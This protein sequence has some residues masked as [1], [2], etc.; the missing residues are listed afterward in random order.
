MSLIPGTLPSG[1]CYGTPQ[2]LL[3]L[4]AQYLDVPAFAVS[5]KVLYSGTSPMP[6]TDF[7]WVD[8][9]GGTT[10]ILKLYNEIIGDYEEYPFQGQLS[11]AGAETLISGKSAITTLAPNDLFLVSQAGTSAVLKK[12][13]YANLIPAPVSLNRSVVLSDVKAQNTSGGT[14]T[15]GA[16]RTRTL[17]TEDY[18]PNNWC[19]LA[20]N[21]FTLVAGTWEIYASAPAAEVNAHKAR[22]QNITDGTTTIVGTSEYVSSSYTNVNTRSIIVGAFTIA[23][24]KTFEIQHYTLTTSS[25]GFG[26]QSNIPSTSE[27]YTVV[28]LRKVV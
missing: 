19:T 21:Q 9:A 6:N 8:T 13:T 26:W 27:V 1:A 5:S 24:T 15:S 25:V 28:H 17:N 4:F 16:W 7:V 23:A 14:F 20:S 10:P 3:E 22:L 12:V 18:D 2:D 11:P